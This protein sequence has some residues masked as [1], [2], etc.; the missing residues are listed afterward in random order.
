MNYL[1]LAFAGKMGGAVTKKGAMLQ[2]GED[3]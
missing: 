1:T 2:N 3:S